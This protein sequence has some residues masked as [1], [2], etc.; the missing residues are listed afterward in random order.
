MNGI[1]Y[2][3]TALCAL[4]IFLGGFELLTPKGKLENIMK[5]VLG[6]TLLVSMVG[7]I[8]GADFSDFSKITAKSDV[9][10]SS[11]VIYAS[12]NQVEYMAA[13]LLSGNSINFKKIEAETDIS[14][15]G[16]ISI[17]RIDV[18]SDYNSEKITE[19][20]NSYF[21]V[22]QVRVIND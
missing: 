4:L 13:A 22:L 9:N 16:S 6:L 2:I 19:I 12:E 20:L 1:K 14:K 8:T 3:L 17:S 7:I 21:D 5:Y 11:A 18:Y 15:Q 10:A